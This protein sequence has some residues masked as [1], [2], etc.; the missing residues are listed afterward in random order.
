MGLVIGGLGKALALVVLAHEGAD[1]AGAR[2]AL[3]A[4]KRDAVELCLQLLVVGNAARHDKPK[5]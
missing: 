4:D 5:H 2:K 1:H 3:A